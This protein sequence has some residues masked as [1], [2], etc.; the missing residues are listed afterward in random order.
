MISTLFLL[1]FS[2]VGYFSE[3]FS[4]AWHSFFGTAKFNVIHLHC[5]KS[6]NRC[7]WPFHRFNS[8]YSFCFS[9]GDFWMWVV[10]VV[11]YVDAV[12]RWISQHIH[13]FIYSLFKSK[14][15]GFHTG[16][17]QFMNKKTHHEV[18]LG[19][20][21]EKCQCLSALDQLRVLG[22]WVY[23]D[24]ICAWISIYGLMR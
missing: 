19:V 5:L 12:R 18:W 15:I 7:L 22:V 17:I 6:L 14:S 21:S 10:V 13:M 23:S 4:D 24:V 1:L 3:M 16:E 20:V 9:F 11:V 2:G 8:L